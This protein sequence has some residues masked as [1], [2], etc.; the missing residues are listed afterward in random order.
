MTREDIQ[1]PKKDDDLIDL[2]DLFAKFDFE[3]SKKQE[4]SLKTGPL[5]SAPKGPVFNKD[6]K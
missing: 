5:A 6:F 4:C 3:D 2:F 1:Q